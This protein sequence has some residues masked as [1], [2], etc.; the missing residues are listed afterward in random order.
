MSIRTRFYR[1]F[2]SN[3]E[4]TY[5]ALILLVLSILTI[6]PM[7][8]VFALSVYAEGVAFFSGFTLAHWSEL[9]LQ[10]RHLIWTTAIYA[11]GA[12]AV[13]TALGVFTSWAIAR[14]NMPLS[15]FYYYLV[16]GMLFLPPIVWETVWIQLMARNG[17]YST[18]IPFDFQFYSIPGMILVQSVFMLPLSMIVLMPVFENVNSSLEEA[19]RISGAGILRTTRSITLPIA[20]PG[21]LAAFLLVLVLSLG[22]LRVPL[23]IGQPGQIDVLP[24]AIYNH[25]ASESVEYGKAFAKSSMLILLA[26][27]VFYLYKRILG[28][29]G[30]YETVSGVSQKASIQLGWSRYALSG[31][32]A[33]ILLV[34]AI[35][36]FLVMV[37]GSLSPFLTP[38]PRIFL[39]ESPATVEWY[40][41]LLTD[42]R[43]HSAALNSLFA[44]GLATLLTIVGAILI[45]WV[46]YKSDIA[47][48]SA[49]DYLAF[50]PIALTSVSLAVGFIAIYLGYVRIGIYGTIWIVVLAYLTRSLPTT[51][52]VVV[53]SIQQLHDE[54]LEAAVI[55]GA[56]K[57]TRVR[58]VVVP[59]IMS[60][61]HAIGAWRF[62]ILYK[63][64]PMSILLA[65]R[66]VD[67]I[68]P[69]LF[70]LGVQANFPQL[71]A[72]GVALTVFLALVTI[73]IHQIPAYGGS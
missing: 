21:I 11:F 69:Y 3:R 43:L 68:A 44:A 42:G 65:P 12:A 22:T 36:P 29:T 45:A 17:F 37:H 38:F 33:F 66:D 13:T 54:V 8:T 14:T 58:T 30:Q 67:L 18:L 53:P 63:E 32:V 51:T 64:F 6:L 27:P 4:R 5:G 46:V 25:I 62:A 26:L 40:A 52:R 72:I 39:G 71:S 49:I 50:L 57:L 24:T 16:F 10:S 31:I 7:A 48:G 55:S 41:S 2:A 56:N 19:S 20:T 73:L 9:L 23:L 28:E 47:Y 15:R 61:V 60:S 34:L 1:S 70:E 35:I 59:L